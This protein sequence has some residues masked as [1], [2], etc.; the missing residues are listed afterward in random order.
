MHQTAE[1]AIAIVAPLGSFITFIVV[2]WLIV[3]TRQRRNELRAEVQMKLIEKFGSSAEFVHFL[4]SQ[5]G[6]DFLHQPMID[7]RRR[8]IAGISA[9]SV[10]GCLGLGFLV[11]GFGDDGF[12]VPAFILIALGAGFI[13]SATLSM[14]LMKRL[15]SNFTPSQP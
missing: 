10:M 3:R 1:T 4:E 11:L 13:V 6:R 9:G 12:F 5:A 14:K 2:I 8:V 7:A 15:P